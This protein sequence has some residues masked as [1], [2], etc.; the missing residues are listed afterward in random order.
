MII[1]KGLEAHQVIAIS[2]TAHAWVSGQ[3]ARQWGNERF[4][5]CAPIEPLCYAAEQHDRGFLDWERQPTLNPKSGLP[6]TFEDIPLS[7][8]NAAAIY[9][10]HGE[11]VSR[12]REHYALIADC[13]HL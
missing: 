4:P 1:Q 6:H 10:P 13:I 11:A 2:Q 12:P 8:Q 9:Q 5:S 3:L 7:L